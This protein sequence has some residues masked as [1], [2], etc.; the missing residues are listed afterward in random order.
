MP[1]NIELK[2]KLNNRNLAKNFISKQKWIF[3]K[4]YAKTAPHEY[5]MVFP[6]SPYKKEAQGFY[7]LIQEYGYAKKFY[8]KKFRYLNIDGYKYWP[9]ISKDGFNRDW[10]INRE[11]LNENHN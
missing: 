7:Y 10:S 3:A 1:S 6:N 4:T 9:M 11:K 5:I 2:A 8:N